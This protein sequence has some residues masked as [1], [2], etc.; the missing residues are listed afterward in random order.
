MRNEVLY[1]TKG[2]FTKDTKPLHVKEKSL[3]TSCHDCKYDDIDV[4]EN[5]R[6]AHCIPCLEPVTLRKNYTKN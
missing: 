5:E 1:L 2:N 4:D 6:K 3:Q